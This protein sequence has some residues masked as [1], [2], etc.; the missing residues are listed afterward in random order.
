METECHAN[1][2]RPTFQHNPD[3]AIP[4]DPS[5]GIATEYPEGLEFRFI[6]RIPRLAMWSLKGR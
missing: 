5:D 4:A 1:P 6:E 2:Q 3:R